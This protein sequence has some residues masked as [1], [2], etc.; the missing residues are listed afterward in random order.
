MFIFAFILVSKVSKKKKQR[1]ESLLFGNTFIFKAEHF[2]EPL[3][4]FMKRENSALTPDKINKHSCM[5]ESLFYLVRV[6]KLKIEQMHNKLWSTLLSLR[7]GGFSLNL[8][9]W[10]QTHL[11]N[12]K[13]SSD[14]G[15]QTIELSQSSS[16]PN[17]I[18]PAKLYISSKN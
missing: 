17:S 10:N 13:R 12:F 8:L 18:N 7:D 6:W 9:K 2:L 14:S 15:Q 1:R 3:Q 11:L 16:D 5:K 4:I